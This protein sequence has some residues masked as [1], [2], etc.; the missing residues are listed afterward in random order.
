[1]LWRIRGFV[2]DIS[3]IL[4]GTRK[5]GDLN[6]VLK[7]IYML[8]PKIFEITSFK[9]F[10]KNKEQT[11]KSSALKRKGISCRIMEFIEFW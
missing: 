1:M 3:D 7:P 5:W 8:S 6:I 10:M 2:N 9:R 11:A 4:I